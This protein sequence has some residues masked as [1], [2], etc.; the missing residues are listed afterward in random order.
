MKPSLSII[1]LSLV[2]VSCAQHPDSFLV[3]TAPPRDVPPQT[4]RAKELKINSANSKIFWVGTKPTGQHRGTIAISDGAIIFQ[5]EVPVGGNFTMDMHDIQVLELEETQ[6]AKLTN[7]LMSSDFFDVANHPVSKFVLTNITPYDSQE[8]QGPGAESP[9]ILADPTHMATGNFSMR[10]TNLSISFPVKIKVLEGHLEAE[11]KFN[12]D[13]TKWGVSYW[14]ESTIESRTKDKL[15]HNVVHV[16][17][18]L[19]GSR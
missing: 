6:K 19:E 2:G 10:G 15:I 9:Y 18:V 4:A 8:S 3:K 5:D 12:I 17:F 13:R 16:G 7:H 14:D 1:V 11:A